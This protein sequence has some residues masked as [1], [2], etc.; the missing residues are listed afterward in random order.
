LRELRLLGLTY[1]VRISRTAISMGADFSNA[2]LRGVDFT[3]ASL[4]DIKLQDADTKGAVSL[5]LAA[6]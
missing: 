4:S 2:S 6:V 3:D 5:L 1:Q